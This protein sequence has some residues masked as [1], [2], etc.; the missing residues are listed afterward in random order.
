[1]IKNTLER[2]SMYS[3]I[4]NMD[5]DL[6]VHHEYKQTAQKRRK[7]PRLGSL[8]LCSK[9]VIPHKMQ[10]TTYTERF[11]ADLIEC[12]IKDFFNF[13]EKKIKLKLKNRKMSLALSQQDCP[14][15]NPIEIGGIR[16]TSPTQENMLTKSSTKNLKKSKKLTEKIKSNTMDFF[17]NGDEHVST[18]SS[19]SMIEHEDP[20][21]GT[22]D[23]YNGQ[24]GEACHFYCGCSQSSLEAKFKEKK[25]FDQFYNSIKENLRSQFEQNPHLVGKIQKVLD[26]K[27]NGDLD[28]GSLAFVFGIEIGNQGCNDADYAVFE[29]ICRVFNL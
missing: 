11:P 17:S 8:K 5:K 18:C 6:T 15:G 4:S 14:P 3:G 23:R 24:E 1:M 25:R 29:E 28:F 26:L 7:R 19:I 21:A 16:K 2:A 22:E 12:L 27:K 20:K 10:S 9:P 13:S